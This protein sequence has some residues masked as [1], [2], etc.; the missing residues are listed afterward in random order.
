MDGRSASKQAGRRKA[1]LVGGKDDVNN[2][3]SVVVPPTCSQG[4]SGVQI[5]SGSAISELKV[6]SAR[7]GVRS[8][9]GF[10]VLNSSCCSGLW[11]HVSDLGPRRR[12]LSPSGANS[13]RHRMLEF[14]RLEFA[15]RFHSGK[16]VS[17]ESF[18]HPKPFRA[19]A[20][21]GLQRC[22]VARRNMFN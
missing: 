12:R 18:R 11:T 20:I 15:G 1:R 3:S 22:S 21:S 19:V 16:L 9:A 8:T 14:F 2:H 6:C 10:S 17:D 7:L 13:Q 4:N 5:S